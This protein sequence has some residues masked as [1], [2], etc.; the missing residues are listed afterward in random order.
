MN[1]YSPTVKLNLVHGLVCWTCK[2]WWS[3]DQILPES[4]LKL[5]SI[6]CYRFLIFFVERIYFITDFYFVRYIIK[7]LHHCKVCDCW[8]LINS[9][10]VFCIV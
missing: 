7:G 5:L 1:V 2:Q 8:Q 9:I 10:H 3:H 6:V 4:V